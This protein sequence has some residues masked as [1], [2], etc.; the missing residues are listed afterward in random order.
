MAYIRSRDG[1]VKPSGALSAKGKE[2]KQKRVINIDDDFDADMDGEDDIQEHEQD[3]IF[4]QKLDTEFPLSGG[5]TD[6][7]D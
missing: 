6:G 2:L 1:H 7:D 3:R 5:E 4:Q